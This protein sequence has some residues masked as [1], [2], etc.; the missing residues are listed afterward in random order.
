MA[1]SQITK[2]EIWKFKQKKDE[3]LSMAFST[4]E[5][6]FCRTVFD[7]AK[8]YKGWKPTAPSLDV[9]NR[10]KPT[11]KDNLQIICVQCNTAK[12]KLGQEE[13][14]AWI[15]RVYINLLGKP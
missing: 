5:C 6:P 2:T 13:F 10:D 9:I 4:K 15:R 7:Y 14:K 3:V 8:D 1:L 12:S 11:T